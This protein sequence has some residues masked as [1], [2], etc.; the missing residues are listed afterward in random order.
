[1]TDPTHGKRPMK[2]Y[3]LVLSNLCSR[4]KLLFDHTTA[5]TASALLRIISMS[6]YSNIIVFIL[7]SLFVFVKHTKKWVSAVP[8]LFFLVA[9][10]FILAFLV[11]CDDATSKF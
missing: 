2:Y 11:G 1:M 7:L 5:S 9:A 10:P 8:T 3:C 6:V 4:H